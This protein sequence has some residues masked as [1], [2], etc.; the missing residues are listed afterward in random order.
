MHLLRFVTLFALVFSTSALACVP[1]FSAKGKELQRLVLARFDAAKYVV[2]AEVIRSSERDADPR[3]LRFTPAKWT[4][5]R[6]WKGKVDV[7]ASIVTHDGGS[8]C[9]DVPKK[10][11][12]RVFY[13]SSMGS[14]MQDHESAGNVNGDTKEQ[15]SILESLVAGPRA[16]PNI[17]LQADRER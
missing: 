12:R 4:V 11:E 1:S 13:L 16:Q 6:V 8:D 5:I 17:S 7:G 9:S 14:D 10:G 15:V 2:Y 3:Y